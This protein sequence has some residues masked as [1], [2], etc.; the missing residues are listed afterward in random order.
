VVLYQRFGEGAA[1]I[2]DEAAKAGSLL[3]ETTL[4]GTGR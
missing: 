1:L 2:A 3:R 4:K